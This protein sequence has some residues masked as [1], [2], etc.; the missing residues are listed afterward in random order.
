MQRAVLFCKLILKFYSK[1]D[2]KVESLFSDLIKIR[3]SC[4]WVVWFTLFIITAVKK[5]EKTSI[6]CAANFFY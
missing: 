2:W 3:I 4:E 6:F 1:I 5:I